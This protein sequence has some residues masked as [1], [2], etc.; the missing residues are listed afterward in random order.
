M[1]SGSTLRESRLPNAYKKFK[2]FLSG[3][4]KDLPYVLSIDESPMDN[5]NSIV[6]V[7]LSTWRHTSVALTAFFP[8]GSTNSKLVVES[9]LAT[10]D[11][12]DLN[13]RLFRGL[14]G[15]NGKSMR[16]YTS[17]ATLLEWY[18]H[19]SVCPLLGTWIKPVCEI[20]CRGFSE[21]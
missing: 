5:G 17:A 11:E 7:L 9:V 21:R 12:Y 6:C 8:D 13:P 15:D 3:E 19:S 16:R 18:F 1:P 10:I 2:H 14:C 4:I 20:F